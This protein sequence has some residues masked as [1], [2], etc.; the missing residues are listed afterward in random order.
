MAS[1]AI[2][3]RMVNSSGIGVYIKNLIPY[4]QQHFKL[5]LIGNSTELANYVKEGDTVIVPVVASIYTLTEQLELF[6]KIPRCDIF[7]SPH[8]NVP[9]LPIA[10]KKR[11]VTIH[12]TYHLAYK[13][14]LSLPQKIF[15]NFFMKAATKLSDKII[16]VSEFSK[17]EIIKYTG[18]SASKINTIHNGVD[19]K[20]FREIEATSFP[21][22]LV[23]LP[24]K[25]ILYVG[26]V[27]PHKNLLTL[28]K[29]FSKFTEDDH[30]NY[31]LLIVGKKEGFITS[32]TQIAK[33]L[34]SNRNLENQVVFTGFVDDKDLPFI[35]NAA[36]LFVFPSLYEGF[37]LP[38]LEA[39]ACGCPVVA[40]SAASIPE[41]CGN[42][43][44]YFYPTDSDTLALLIKKLLNDKIASNKL[45]ELG[46]QQVSNFTWSSASEKHIKLFESLL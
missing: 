29:A 34:Q 46:R 31:K 4:L 9:A 45:I 24:E 13:D 6:K 38:P 18:C 26:N 20:H 40:T 11:V 25:Y 36:S 5:Y 44:A 19:Q 42:A 10:S 8:Y 35:Y 17:Q 21:Q 1:V 28:L 7:W 43:A 16:T 39:M 22:N 27:K 2:D 3:A 37:G 14:S 30:H 12:D 33:L 32:D 15:A 41:V 23:I